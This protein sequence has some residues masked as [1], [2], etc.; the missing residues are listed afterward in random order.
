MGESN[1]EPPALDFTIAVYWMNCE[2]RMPGENL[3]N[4]YFSHEPAMRRPIRRGMRAWVEW[5][6]VGWLGGSPSIFRHAGGRICSDLILFIPR[7]MKQKNTVV[8]IL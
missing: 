3:R 5:K 6:I 4:F 7:R 1:L 2:G 8:I